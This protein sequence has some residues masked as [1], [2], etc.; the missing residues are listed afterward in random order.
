MTCNIF[1]CRALLMVCLF[2]GAP[3]RAPPSARA[4]AAACLGPGR[5]GR[6]SAALGLAGPGLHPGPFQPG[7]M[8]TACAA[9]RRE[10]AW[11][12]VRPFRP[13]RRQGQSNALG[14]AARRRRR[15]VGAP[16]APGRPHHRQ[17]G[18]EPH[19]EAV[20]LRPGARGALLLGGGAGLGA[21]GQ[22][23]NG[24]QPA[25][26]PAALG[27]GRG[28]DPPPALGGASCDRTRTRPGR[29]PRRPRPRPPTPPGAPLPRNAQAES[30]SNPAASGVFH[31][32]ATLIVEAGGFY[33][34]PR[35]NTATHNGEQA[36]RRR[37]RRGG[38]A[39]GERR[40][41]LRGGPGRA[42]LRQSQQTE[43]RGG[44]RQS[45]G[46]ECKRPHRAQ[47]A[48]A[49]AGVGEGQGVGRRAAHQRRRLWRAGQRNDRHRARQASA[50][51]CARGQG[52]RTQ[53]C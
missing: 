3:G 38:G 50:C 40:G 46:G 39:A 7:N 8:G 52:R 14:P 2:S 45:P 41:T 23:R 34:G 35:S 36:R 51:A 37:R 42:R 6:A 22:E 17:P 10:R 18:Q 26:Q 12:A 32:E 29:R 48:A 1:L 20:R 47:T 44:G 31:N 13:R 15:I 27:H 21:A 9:A 24:R 43:G 16:A 11:S 49:H 4:L 25:A 30:R 19:Q 33:P 5:P 53:A 28:C